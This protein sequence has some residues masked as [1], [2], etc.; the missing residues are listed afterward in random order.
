LPG[1]RVVVTKRMV[2]TKLSAIVK[3][4]DM[5]RYIL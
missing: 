3:D 1:K 5:T 4:E 2:L